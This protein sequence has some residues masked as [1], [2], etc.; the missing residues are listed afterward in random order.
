MSSLRGEWIFTAVLPFDG[1]TFVLVVISSLQ[2]ILSQLLFPSAFPIPTLDRCAS[3]DTTCP[4]TPLLNDEIR[5]RV[6]MSPRAVRLSFLSLLSCRSLRRQISSLNI[7]P[8][9]DRFQ[10]RRVDAVPY[11]AEMVDF[12][13]RRDRANRKFVC[14]TVSKRCSLLLMKSKPSVAEF[15]LTCHPEPAFSGSVNF[16]PEPFIKRS[17]RSTKR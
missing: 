5:A 2:A 17:A 1:G 9:L 7:D 15:V 12:K 6:W 13:I 4:A 10:V 11:S 8:V 16:F 3:A 14:N